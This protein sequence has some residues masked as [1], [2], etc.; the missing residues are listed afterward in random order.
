VR[1]VREDHDPPAFTRVIEQP[2]ERL[3]DPL[4]PGVR[5][6]AVDE[7]LEHVHDDER[8]HQLSSQQFAIVSR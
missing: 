4:R 1:V 8:L 6:L 2:P 3:G 7:V 5:E